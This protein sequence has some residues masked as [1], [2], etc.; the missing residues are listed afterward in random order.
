MHFP[1]KKEKLLIK[2]SKKEGS[3]ATCTSPI[4]HLIFGPKLLH[5]LCFSFLVGIR[6][7][8]RE[9]ENNAYASFWGTNKVRYGRV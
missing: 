1:V 8:Q 4:M 3:Y 6:A 2:N 7:I 5:D 9:I